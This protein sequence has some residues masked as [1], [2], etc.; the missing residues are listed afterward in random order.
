MNE[1]TEAVTELRTIERK[2]DAGQAAKKE[3]LGREIDERK[4]RQ[5]ETLKEAL[6]RGWKNGRLMG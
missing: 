5:I 2:D 3:E 1:L 4:A 6:E